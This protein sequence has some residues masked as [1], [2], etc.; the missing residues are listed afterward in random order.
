MDGQAVP[1][2]TWGVVMGQW[3]DNPKRRRRSRTSSFE[4]GERKKQLGTC[5]PI[6]LLRELQ[7]RARKDERTLSNYVACVLEAAVQVGLG[8]LKVL[9]GAFDK[10]IDDKFA[11]PLW[12]KENDA[13][14]V[15]EWRD[16]GKD[17][18]VEHKRDGASPY[19]LC[20]ELPLAVGEKSGDF[21]NSVVWFDLRP[22]G[23]VE[24]V[25]TRG[26]SLI[27]RGHGAWNEKT[28][29]NVPKLEMMAATLWSALRERVPE[30]DATVTRARML[31][32]D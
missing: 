11:L 9:D 20:Y 1:A 22:D 30:E 15:I 5:V 17:I 25:K 12:V 8:P 14:W 29:P 19:Q 2:R 21:R 13:V 7:R 18:K 16:G 6:K 28:G 4:G 3:F 26:S 10:N 32:L 23:S 24:W 27:G 31:E